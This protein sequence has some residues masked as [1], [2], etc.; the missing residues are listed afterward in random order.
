MWLKL[1][2]REPKESAN[3]GLVDGSLDY[4]GMILHQI[5]ETDSFKIFSEACEVTWGQLNANRREF[6]V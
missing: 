4:G 6:E 1:I 2:P 5:L 3:A